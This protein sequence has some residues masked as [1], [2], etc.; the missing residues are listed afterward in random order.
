MKKL[1]LSELEGW[2][3]RLYM[4]VKTQCRQMKKR[5][6]KQQLIKQYS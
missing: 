3:W 5:E 4:F 2:M 6:R 1:P